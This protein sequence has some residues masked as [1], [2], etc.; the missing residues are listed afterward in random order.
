MFLN[1]EKLEF[2]GHEERDESV[3]LRR[4]EGRRETKATRERECCMADLDPL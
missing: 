3:A 4:R 1:V 2:K